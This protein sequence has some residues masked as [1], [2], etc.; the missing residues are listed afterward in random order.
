VKAIKVGTTLKNTFTGDTFTIEEILIVW[1]VT[2]EWKVVFITDHYGTCSAEHME[3]GLNS[4]TI[5][6]VTQ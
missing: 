4:G 5:V 1:Q 2:S 6:E 3:R